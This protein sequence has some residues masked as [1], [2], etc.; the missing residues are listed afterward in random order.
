MNT[1][2]KAFLTGATVIMLCSTTMHAQKWSIATNLLDYLNFLTINAEAGV[3]LER[4]WSLTAEARYNPFNFKACRE[5]V[6]NKK[7]TL[8][9]GTR[10]WP[11]F[12]Y[13]GF[14]YGGKIQ[15]MQFNTG[16]LFSPRT[17]EGNAVGIGFNFG[18]S[19]ML[20]EHLN[21]EF[22]IGLWFGGMNYTEYS[23]PVCG[24]KIESGRKAFIA[25]D[26]FQINLLYYF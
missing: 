6:H 21:I 24:R 22:G 14:Y 4:H 3:T 13:S 25:P 12:V 2:A 20:T 9:A 16:G 7:L 11:F 19:L 23:S 5:P 10:Y 15:W 8:S 26:D 18:Y 17:R 1:K